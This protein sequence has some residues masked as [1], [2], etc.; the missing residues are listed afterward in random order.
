MTKKPLDSAFLGGD[1]ASY[2]T[3]AKRFLAHK[4]LL[5]Q[6]L[7]ELVEEFHDCSPHDIAEKYIEGEPAINIR[8]IPMDADLTNTVKQKSGSK[9]EKIKGQRN[10]DSSPTEG[11]VVFDILFHAT[12][13][14][15]KEPIT[16]IIN[17]EPQRSLYTGY[18]L[19]RRAIYYACR[20]IS[21]Q[22]EREFHGDDYGGMRK[23]YT[24]WLVMHTP[25]NAANSIQ[26]YHITEKS[27]YGKKHEEKKNYD[28]LVAIMVNLGTL[29]S[30]QRLLKFLRL[31]FLDERKAAEKTKIL[32]DEYDLTL[33]KNMEGAWT[34]M[35]SLAAGIAEQAALKGE[36]RG[37]RRGEKRGIRIGFKQGEECGEK[38]G[39]KQGEDR[40]MAALRM[41]KKN[42]PLE[43][44]VEKT[45]LTLARLTELKAII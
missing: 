2:D 13:P 22:K 12:L 32:R 35:T 28:L 37:E 39:E 25:K 1:Q 27:L 11:T 41:L 36:R 30:K 38:R 9:P 10:E 19:I 40:M 8:E 5:A 21:S 7:K 14:T 24:I 29:P 44:I 17:I 15:T 34:K 20:L 42:L 18:P 31:I 33:T 45:G 43:T 3:I 6:I 26:R 23:V 16:L 4:S